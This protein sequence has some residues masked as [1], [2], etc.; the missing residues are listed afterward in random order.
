MYRQGICTNKRTCEIGLR[1]R[2]FHI[3]AGSVLTVWTKVENVLCSLTGSQQFRLQIIRIRTKD[4][5][6]IVGCVIPS[7]CLGQ[8]D[9]LLNSLSSRTY[10]Q[11]YSNE[12][13]PIVIDDG[14]EAPSSTSLA[15]SSGS[16]SSGSFFMNIQNGA[17]NGKNIFNY[18]KGSNNSYEQIGTASSYR[19]ANANGTRM[20][21]N[22]VGRNASFHLHM[23]HLNV[24]ANRNLEFI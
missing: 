8:V 18:V 16:A 21:G 9:S 17:G 14:C 6:K 24:A 19:Y 15:N 10:K 2:R 3:L 20:N 12:D 4:N 1:N 13:D 7:M 11:D 23:N 5:K 22:G